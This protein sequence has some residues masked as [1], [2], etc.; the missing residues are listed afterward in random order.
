[1]KRTVSAFVLV[2]V[3]ILAVCGCSN[4]ATPFLG[5]WNYDLAEG[6]LGM[7]YHFEKK[8]VLKAQTLLGEAEG[9]PE[10]SMGTYKVVD[11]DTIILTDTMGLEEEYTY[12]FTKNGTKLTMTGEEYIMIFTKAEN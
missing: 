2:L 10:L 3:L 11:E 5:K 6:G 9:K 8:G 4:R 12:E 7:Y 1:M